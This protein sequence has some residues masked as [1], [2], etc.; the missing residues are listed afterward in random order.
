MAYSKW[1]YI[2]KYVCVSSRLFNNNCIN[3]NKNK[4]T[5]DT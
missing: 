3:K 2:R 1:L 4:N 5:T